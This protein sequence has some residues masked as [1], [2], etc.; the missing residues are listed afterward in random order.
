MTKQ[1]PMT[2]QHDEIEDD[3]EGFDY[4]DEMHDHCDDGM[5]DMMSSLISASRDQM[6]AAIDLTT[7]VIDA[8]GSDSMKEEQVFAL[9]KRAS[10]VIAENSPLKDLLTQFGGE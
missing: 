2:H 8:S 3:F 10:A 1:T 5:A 9:F 7:L 6:A 4:I